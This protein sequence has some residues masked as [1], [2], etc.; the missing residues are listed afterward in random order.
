MLEK[1]KKAVVFTFVSLLA[2]SLPI[3]FAFKGKGT[4]DEK[5]DPVYFPSTVTDDFFRE[6][7]DFFANNVPFR[8]QFISYYNSVDESI[9]KAF[10]DFLLLLSGK[11]SFDYPSSGSIDDITDPYLDKGQPYYA[12]RYNGYVIYGR[13]DWLFYS[14]D[15]A[16]ENYKGSDILSDYEMSK[17]LEKFTAV[18]NLCVSKGIDVSFTVFPNKEQVYADK[19][20]SIK[21][22]N[23]AKKLQRIE[24]YFNKN[25]SLPFSYPLDELIDSRSNGD[26]YL[27]ED[28]HWNPLG[29]M[30]GYNDILKGLGREATTFTYEETTV[31][32]GDLASLLSSSGTIYTSYDV[33]YKNDVTYEVV[34][35]GGR[36]YVE[37]K[38]SLTDGSRCVIIGDSYRN[39][40]IPYAAK[41][42][43]NLTCIHFDYLDSEYAQN[44]IAKLEAGDTLIVLSVERLYPS[45]VKSLD[46]LASH[47]DK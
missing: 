36:K 10:F 23:R 24:H 43:E 13:D 18:N 31:Q 29:A 33:A 15:G 27:K 3:S 35:D 21:V 34:N 42:Y 5:K 14:G 47:L 20:P 45:L 28:T 37:T 19:M 9:E 39:A 12:P 30:Y 8:E 38:S 40:I 41:D 46:F 32:G 4:I 22:K 7:D 26:V 1:F 16:L 17:N 11:T 44:E 6:F 2:V 25:S